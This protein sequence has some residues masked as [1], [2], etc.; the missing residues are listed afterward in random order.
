MIRKWLCRWFRLTRN[1]DVP[2]PQDT[3]GH[4]DDLWEVKDV[5]VWFPRM[6][7]SEEWKRDL[8]PFFKQSLLRTF[9][10]MSYEKAA[11]KLRRL[12]ERALLINEWLETPHIMVNKE[13]AMLNNAFGSGRDDRLDK[14]LE[15]ANS[16]G[17]R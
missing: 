9:V 10:A 17:G 6:L 3:S 13:E 15:R 1:E 11:D 8:E 5:K 7:N 4:W 14:A 16:N 12:Q 2:I